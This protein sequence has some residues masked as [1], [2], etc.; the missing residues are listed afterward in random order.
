[1]KFPQAITLRGLRWMLAS[2]MVACLTIFPAIAFGQKTTGSQDALIQQTLI[3]E[4]APSPIVFPNRTMFCENLNLLPDTSNG[5]AFTR[6][7]D[8]DELIMEFA[9]NGVFQYRTYTSPQGPVFLWGTEPSPVKS[10]MLA[11]AGN[12]ILSFSSQIQVLAIIV[13]AGVDTYVFSYAYPTS[14]ITYSDINLNT[15]SLQN[16]NRVNICWGTAVAPSA[17]TA[18]VSGRV[19]DA[20]GF[21]IS[22]AVISATDAASGDVL[23]SRTNAFGYY[24]FDSLIVG[25]VYV[26]AASHKRYAFPEPTRTISLTEDLADFDFI[27]NP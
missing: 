7:T 1:M 25:Q 14:P 10:V 9:P 6:I 27:A 19:I 23:R 17:A 24:T 13:R 5:G 26:I 15:G 11:T 2:T 22:G 12:T 21:G 16:V 4:A 8:D 18:R 20:N 3:P